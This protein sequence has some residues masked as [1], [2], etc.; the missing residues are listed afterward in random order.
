MNSREASSREFIIGTE[1]GILHTLRKQS[2]EKSFF[3]PSP[4]LICP[5]MKRI[6][7]GDIIIALKEKR[8]Q[9]TI[10]EDMRL[11]ALAAVERM[12]AVP[13]D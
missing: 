8:H 9:V 7:L 10:P 1:M 6:T 3:S 4:H 12:L 13:R 5:D 11:R 2:P